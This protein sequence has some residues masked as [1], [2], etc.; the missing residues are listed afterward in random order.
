MS[1]G[2]CIKMVLSLL[3]VEVKWKFWQDFKYMPFRQKG[4][5]QLFIL[6]KSRRALRKAHPFG[7]KSFSNFKDFS[8]FF[9]L[10]R[11]RT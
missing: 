11:G 9:E 8:L 1:I 6:G 7:S 10:D 5:I 4:T 3:L 2:T